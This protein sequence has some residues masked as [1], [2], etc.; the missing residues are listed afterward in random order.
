MTG[1]E[2][3]VLAI[4]T[5]R[6]RAGDPE[7]RI[8]PTAIDKRPR[9]GP[10]PIAASGL[11]GDEQADPRHHGGPDQAV[12][13]YPFEHY[14]A[15]R[16]EL[17]LL[18]PLPHGTFGENVTLRGVLEHE[19]AIGDT[20]TRDGL[21][22]EVSA[23]RVPCAKLDRKLGARVGARMLETAR[24]GFYARVLSPGSLEA[25]TTMRFDVVPGDRSGESASPL[26]RITIAEL[27]RWRGG[28]GDAG[29]EERARFARRAADHRA[30]AE[31]WRE[32]VGRAL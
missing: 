21:V 16:G 22:L 18:E 9:R 11:D 28:V 3:E 13:V 20:L 15:W 12:Y 23:P 14:E 25:G 24:T 26:D 31:R 1:R 30:L 4:C 5:G 19:V 17:G 8:G 6:A 27:A 2:V 29:P 10:V 32:A 7:A